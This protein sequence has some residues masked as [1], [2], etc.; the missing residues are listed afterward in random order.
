MNY[1]VCMAI[2]K[3]IYIETTVWH[4]SNICIQL[5]YTIP[6]YVVTNINNNI[7]ALSDCFILPSILA[8]SVLYLIESHDTVTKSLRPLWP[9][10]TI[11]LGCFIP[12]SQIILHI[13][14][15]LGADYQ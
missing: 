15:Q 4:L 8:G 7:L 9:H 14:M 3:I 12:A 11:G 1:L 10:A 5:Q 2:I 13:L 6:A